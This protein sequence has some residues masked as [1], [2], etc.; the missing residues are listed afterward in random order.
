MLEGIK[1]S[2]AESICAND[3]KGHAKGSP[4]FTPKLSRVVR[5][6]YSKTCKS[7]YFCRR[8]STAAFHVCYKINQRDY[9]MLQGADLDL[10]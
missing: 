3:F 4:V 2:E 9:L 10:N 7:L 6:N 8:V 1:Q 5:G